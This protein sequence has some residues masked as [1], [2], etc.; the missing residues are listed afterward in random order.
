MEVH[1]FEIGGGGKPFFEG[2]L[3]ASG[4]ASL[5]DL[6]FMAREIKPQVLVPIHTESPGFFAK[7]LGKEP[8]EVRL[9]SNGETV[10][11]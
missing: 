3:H 8:I 7:E 11:L 9:V 2:G 4:H 1:G 10:S 5:E 6:L